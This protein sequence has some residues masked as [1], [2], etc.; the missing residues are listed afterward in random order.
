M[1]SPGACFAESKSGNM[2]GGSSRSKA[3]NESGHRAIKCDERR[4]SSSWQFY[5]LRMGPSSE[6]RTLHVVLGTMTGLC[7]TDKRK[8]IW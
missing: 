3:G 1:L 5:K 4:I 8:P 7:E 2:I 6:Y